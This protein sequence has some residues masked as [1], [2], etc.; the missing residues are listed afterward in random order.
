MEPVSGH[1]TRYVSGIGGLA[2]IETDTS[3]PVLQL[4]D[5]HGDIVARASLSETA[6]KLL[7][8]ERPTEYGV[9]TISKPEKYSWLGGDL[10]PTELPSGVVAMGARSY[11]PKLG[12]FLQPDPVPGGTDNPYAYTDGNPVNETD[13][14]GA[15]V[16]GAYLYAFNAEENVRSSEREA[17]REQAAREEAE[18]KAAEAAAI[19][20]M[21][22]KIAAEEAAIPQWMREYAMGGPSL[23]EMMAAKGEVPGGGMAGVGGQ[24]L[25]NQGVNP[26]WLFGA[27]GHG[28][29][30]G[31]HGKL[32][33]PNEGGN[34]C[35]N[36]SG[37]GK[38]HNEGKRIFTEI[39]CYP[40]KW[41]SGVCQDWIE[42]EEAR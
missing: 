23:L 6:T 3:E 14:T 4:T 18:R 37:C 20:A 42:P 22:A 9:P 7:S 15:F 27:A 1:W 41:L 8:T 29:P 39:V 28:N 13:L 26:I 12:R 5:L 17:A 19:A 33:N 36:R 31:G 11:V 25:G 24:D 40:L 34:D 2:A 30:P 32:G 38:D 35:P 21:N 16:E 10:L